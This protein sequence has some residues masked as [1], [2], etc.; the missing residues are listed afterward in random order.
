MAGEMTIRKPTNRECEI[1]GR[2]E[3]WEASGESWVIDTSDGE[4]AVGDPHCIHEWDITG[5]FLP[6][7]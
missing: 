6:Y 4:P 5:T 7:E 1:C 2:R 3:T